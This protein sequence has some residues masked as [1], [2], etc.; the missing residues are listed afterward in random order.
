MFRFST[1]T[2]VRATLHAHRYLLS[3]MLFF[4]C[5]QLYAQFAF[6][7][8]KIAVTAIPSGIRYNG[9]AEEA[10]SWT[11]KLGQNIV[12]TAKQPPE[13]NKPIAEG[14]DETV[15]VTLHAFHFVKKDSAFKLLWKMSDAEKNCPFD[16][17][18]EFVKGAISITDLDANGTAETTLL[19][20]LACRSDVSPSQLKLIMHQD[21]TKHALRG[22]MWLR[23]GE[24]SRFDVT[25]RNV[26]LET[27]NDYKGK[28]AEW[29]K[30]W[31]RYRNEK[32]FAGA[33]AALVQF[34]RRQWLLYVKESFE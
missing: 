19:Y 6:N 13:R 21:S 28:E 22:L 2:C 29:E 16:L 25:E 30:T 17:T 20:R 34:A 31:G 23:S 18:A 5:Q 7:A 9:K 24:D 14:E 4:S 33:S 32:D 1:M 11:D 8:K 12:I 15:S 3:T 26:N 10:W 27:W